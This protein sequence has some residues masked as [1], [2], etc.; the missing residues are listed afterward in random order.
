M[1]Q[2]NQPN[3]PVQATGLIR[4]TATGKVATE[5]RA[6]VER[7]VALNANLLAAA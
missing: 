3:R 7:I 1:T 5:A 6:D 2:T 4:E